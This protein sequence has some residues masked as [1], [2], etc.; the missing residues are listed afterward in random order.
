MVLGGISASTQAEIDLHLHSNISDGVQA[1]DHLVELVMQAGVAVA[2]V[3]DHDSIASALDPTLVA[4]LRALGAQAPRF[5]PGVEFTCWLDTPIRPGCRQEVHVVGL[6]CNPYQPAL[7]AALSRQRLSAIARIRTCVARLNADGYPLRFAEVGFAAARQGL[8]KWHIG[9]ALAAHGYAG[10]AEVAVKTLVSPRFPKP[11]AGTTTALLTPAQAILLIRAAG[12]VAVLAHPQRNVPANDPAAAT[13]LLVSFKMHGLDA[14]EV[15]RVDLPATERPM[16][17]K[18]AQSLGLLLS[19][20]TDY[21]GA[22]D[23]GGPRFPGDAHA[24]LSLWAP[25]EALIHAR[26]GVTDVCD[27][28]PKSLLHANAAERLLL[29]NVQ[30]RRRDSAP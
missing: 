27:V 12:G 26:G 5:V 7:Q 16:Y 1:D 20:G 29:G 13:D 8:H 25:L 18:V 9:K 17:E 24:P 28:A 22:G 30:R 15:Y 11:E 19:G 10:S 3:T 6:G 23:T 21:H 14:V 4:R 2:A